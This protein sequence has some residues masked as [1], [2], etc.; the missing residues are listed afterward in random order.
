MNEIAILNN[1]VDIT[2]KVD[3]IVVRVKTEIK[4]LGLDKIPATEENKKLLKA[5]RSKLN[6]DVKKY[7][8]D[9]K[10]IDKLVNADLDILKEQYKTKIKVLYDLTDKELKD[11]IENITEIQ[12]QVNKDYAL[13]YYN[14]KLLAMPL[15]IGVAYVNVPWNFKFNSSKKSIRATVDVHFEKVETALNIIDNHEYKIQLEELWIRKDFDLAEALI[16]LASRITLAQKIIDQKEE[17]R[18]EKEAKQAETRLQR[19]LVAV[20][21]PRPIIETKVKDLTTIP[22][23]VLATVEEI[24]DYSFIIELTDTQLEAF[25]EYMTER[26]IEFTLVE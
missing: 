25:V 24:T 12:L 13:E 4:A 16:E 21:T 6:K 20:E 7:N 26:E 22:K 14:N 5:T 19:G 17:T 11:K 2:S 8:E 1:D 15:R 10:A 9:I 18:L 3:E 23:K